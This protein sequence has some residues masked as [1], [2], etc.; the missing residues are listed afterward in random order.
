MDNSHN[1]P[2]T[3]RKEDDYTMSNSSDQS[4]GKSKRKEYDAILTKKFGESPAHYTEATTTEEVP[5]APEPDEASSEDDRVAWLEGE[6]A[7]LKLDL[8]NAKAARD[9]HHLRFRKAQTEFEDLQAFCKQLQDENEQLK[10]KDSPPPNSDS[11][12]SWMASTSV[13]PAATPKVNATPPNPVVAN[14]RRG[15]L[16]SELTP[17]NDDTLERPSS[18]SWWQ[19]GRFEE[20]DED[21]D[22][23]SA[24]E[25]SA[26]KNSLVIESLDADEPG[27]TPK[28]QYRST[29]D[30]HL[31]GIHNM[32]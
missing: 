14:S 23:R 25:R 10:S 1:S 9:W 3:V 21:D 8:A 20:N 27:V 29:T 15:S 17:D 32:M 16:C 18:G 4:S 6:V 19:F 12:F 13:P 5:S 7:R 2:R 31:V 11:W 22:N 26:R 30:G 24:V 28:G